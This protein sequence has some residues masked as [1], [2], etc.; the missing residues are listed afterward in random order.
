MNNSPLQFLPSDV[1]V[2]PV[3][4]EQTKLPTLL[5]QLCSHP[6]ISRLHSSISEIDQV[7]MSDKLCIHIHY[8]TLNKT[9]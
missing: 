7:S 9:E 6:S 8:E 5:L 2:Y 1:K 4:Q 3:L